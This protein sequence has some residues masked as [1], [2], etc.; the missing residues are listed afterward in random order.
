MCTEEIALH[1][2]YHGATVTLTITQV[3]SGHKL[4]WMQPGFASGDDHHDLVIDFK[5][6]VDSMANTSLVEGIVNNIFFGPYFVFRIMIMNKTFSQF[7]L[8]LFLV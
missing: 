5:G 1:G 8:R 7:P 6:A 4:R 2:I 3:R